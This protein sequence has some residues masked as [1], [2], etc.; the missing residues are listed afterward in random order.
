MLA[1]AD[2]SENEHQRSAVEAERFTDAYSQLDAFRY[3]I[4]E[5]DAGEYFRDWSAVICDRYAFL[6]HAGW[7]PDVI[8][9]YNFNTGATRFVDQI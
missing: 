4:D 6:M 7:I 3:P 8:K 2:P 9:V 1:L 5:Q